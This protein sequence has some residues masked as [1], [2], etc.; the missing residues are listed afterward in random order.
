MSAFGKAL[1]LGSAIQKQPRKNKQD[2]DNP[3]TLEPSATPQGQATTQGCPLIGPR[4]N[5]E[6][7]RVGEAGDGLDVDKV[8]ERRGNPIENIHMS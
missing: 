6:G 1:T 4:E 8:G 2:Q 5:T 7:G 3:N